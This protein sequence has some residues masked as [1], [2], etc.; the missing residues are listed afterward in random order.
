MTDES[1]SIHS[2][3]VRTCGLASQTT[4]N[5]HQRDTQTSAICIRASPSVLPFTIITLIGDASD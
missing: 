3:C 4:R 2:M 1:Q 5:A